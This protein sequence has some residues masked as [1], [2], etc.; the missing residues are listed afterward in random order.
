MAVK[1]FEGLGR[2]KTSIARVRVYEGKGNNI[3]NDQTLEKYFND[4]KSQSECLDPLKVVGL[5]KDHYFTVVVSGGGVT[6][7]VDAIRLGIGRALVK[8]DPLFKSELR[9]NGFMTRDPRMVERKKYNRRK[10]RKKSQ[11]SKR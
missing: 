3:V 5:D 11:F 10:A 7:Q 9:K 8:K 4:V 6:G 2:R 1:Y